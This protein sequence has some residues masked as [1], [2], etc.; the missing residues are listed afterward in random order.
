MKKGRSPA[1]RPDSLAFTIT[2]EANVQLSVG[3]LSR[4]R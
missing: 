2:P 4:S 3:V 1:E